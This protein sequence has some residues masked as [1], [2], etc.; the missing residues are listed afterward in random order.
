[1][2]IV[3]SLYSLCITSFF[4][5]GSYFPHLIPGRLHLDDVFI[6]AAPTL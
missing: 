5:K 6:A 2:V 3:K 1:L 4:L